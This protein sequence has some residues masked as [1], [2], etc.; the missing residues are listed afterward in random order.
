MID[1]NNAIACSTVNRSPTSRQTSRTLTW[2]QRA[3]TTEECSHGT[4]ETCPTVVAVSWK[5]MILIC[6]S[7]IYMKQKQQ[8]LNGQLEVIRPSR[9][10]FA[11]FLNYWMTIF[12]R[13]TF[14]RLIFR[15]LRW[16]FS[17]ADVSSVDA[18]F[19]ASPGRWQP[20]RRNPS[21]RHTSIERTGRLRQEHK[22]ANLSHEIFTETLK[23]VFGLHR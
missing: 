8:N 5:F 12:M 17:L 6:H 1:F 22:Q 7:K 11:M 18:E 21:F 23:P 19:R 16:P 4:P 9:V 3:A 13:I 14:H 15:R 20:V 10:R 2:S